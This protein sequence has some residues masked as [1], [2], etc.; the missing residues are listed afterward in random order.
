MTS[1]GC[2]AESAGHGGL[3]GCSTSRPACLL[4]ATGTNRDTPRRGGIVMHERAAATTSEA[5]A[6]VGR[7]GCWPEVTR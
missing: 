5:A 3:A 1:A 4:I 7:V 2:A 6:P